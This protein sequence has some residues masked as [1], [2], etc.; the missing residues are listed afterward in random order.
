MPFSLVEEL[1]KLSFCFWIGFRRDQHTV[2]PPKSDALQG[3][4]KTVLPVRKCLRGDELRVVNERGVPSWGAI[5]I[6]A[7]CG[8]DEVRVG[9]KFDIAL[10]VNTS[11][12]R[13][14]GRVPIIIITDDQ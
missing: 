6:I 8:K 12:S 14:S 3:H 1:V 2:P 13:D 11:R 9:L 4:R 5:V 10:S 7:S